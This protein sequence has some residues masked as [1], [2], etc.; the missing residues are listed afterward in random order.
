MKKPQGIDAHGCENPDRE[1]IP[2]CLTVEDE[3]HRVNRHGQQAHACRELPGK[4]RAPSSGGDRDQAQREGA[5]S[6]RVEHEEEVDATRHP[7]DIPLMPVRC[8]DLMRG[9]KQQVERG[10]RLKPGHLKRPPVRARGLAST[11]AQ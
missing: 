8:I 2:E 6:E 1:G 3:K 10:A 7:E 9:Q 5:Y 11:R 4:R